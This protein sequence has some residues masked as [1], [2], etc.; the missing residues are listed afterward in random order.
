MPRSLLVGLLLSL[1]LGHFSRVC[2]QNG[3]S[4]GKCLEEADI[5]GTCR[6]FLGTFL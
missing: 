5:W 4:H 1:C 3:M 6:P 2:S